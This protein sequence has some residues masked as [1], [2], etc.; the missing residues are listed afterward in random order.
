MGLEL[1][2]V[3]VSRTHTHLSHSVGLLW[4]SDQPVA[5]TSTRQ[6][7][8]LTREKHPC[9]GRDSNPQSQQAS[10]R[11]PT[12]LTGGKPVPVVICAQQIPHGLRRCQLSGEITLS[13]YAMTPARFERFAN[14]IHVESATAV[15]ASSD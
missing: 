5:E 14:R 10:S 8:K 9:P 11:R 12:S 13:E 3:E 1:P 4:T 6:H 2:I 7:T 15:R